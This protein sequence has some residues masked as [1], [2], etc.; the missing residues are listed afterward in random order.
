MADNDN[1]TND[2]SDEGEALPEYTIADLVPKFGDLAG[3]VLLAWNAHRAWV[4]AHAAKFG[5]DSPK[6]AAWR[7][8]LPIEALTAGMITPADMADDYG[9]ACNVYDVARFCPDANTVASLIFYLTECLSQAKEN[10][11]GIY[12]N[13]RRSTVADAGDA[14]ALRAQVDNYWTSLRSLAET[15]QLDMAEIRKM[16]P[17]VVKVMPKSGAKRVDY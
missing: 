7:D 3:L 11:A 8:S 15:P 17:T 12:Y 9:E 16:F 14:V 13:A 4:I 2:E 10:L 5:G 6:Y 1:V